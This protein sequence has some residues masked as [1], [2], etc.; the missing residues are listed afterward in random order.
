MA[1]VVSHE[2][3]VVSSES[4]SSD[5]KIAQRKTIVYETRVDPTVVRVA[6]EKL[7]TQ[8]F[9]KF[10]FVKPKSEEILL[11][12]IDKYYEPYMLISGRYSIDYYRKCTYTIRVDNKVLE[13]ILLNSKFEPNRPE[14]PSSNDFKVITLEG[15]ERLMNE[16]KASLILDGYGKEAG[17]SKLPSAPSER[18][19][20]KVLAAFGI[21]E[22]A[23]D[24]DLDIIRSRIIKRPND[25]SRLV[26]EIFEVKERAIIYTPRYRVLYKNTKTD[27]KKSMEFDGVTAERIQQTHTLQF[28]RKIA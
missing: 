10:G 27:E 17:L 12:S 1:E 2:K 11:I 28:L 16:V 4:I 5:E 6:A 18:H 3:I 13:V 22:I 21:R 20:K 7:K 8:L 24:T 15:E 25:V 9:A 14:G 19:P 26:N 23:P